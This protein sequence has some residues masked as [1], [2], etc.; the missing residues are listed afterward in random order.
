MFTSSFITPITQI[1]S[2][3]A[4]IQSY[5]ELPSPSDNPAELT[6]RLSTLMQHMARSGKLKSDAEYHYNTVLSSS[7]I[8]AI[9]TTSKL[10]PSTLNKYVDSLCK[11]Y[12]QIASWADRINRSATHQIDATRT[13]ISYAKSEMSF[14]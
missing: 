1:E 11:D 6:E 9:K 7:I 8:D 3:L 10:S 12:K 5:L 2:E 4:D 13:L 14:R